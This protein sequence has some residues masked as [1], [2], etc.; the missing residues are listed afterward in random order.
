M[1]SFADKNKEKVAQR[2]PNR[3]TKKAAASVYQR[4]ESQHIRTASASANKGS[5]NV[6]LKALLEKANGSTAVQQ[7][8]SMQEQADAKGNKIAP[9]DL[10]QGK[11][12]HAVT[13]KK[14][15]PSGSSATKTALPSQLKSGVEQL[16]G[17]SMDDVQV[18]YNSDQPAQLSAHAF[19]QG[20]D[21]HIAPKQEKHLPHEAW[22]VAQ[23][24]QGRVKATTQ[25]KGKVPVNDDGSLEREADVMGAKALR[26]GTAIQ[27]TLQTK[28]ISS[29]G[30]VQKVGI[31]DKLF[32]KKKEEDASQPSVGTEAATPAT[33]APTTSEPTPEP[34]LQEKIQQ[35]RGLIEMAKH[36]QDILGNAPLWAD[37]SKKPSNT[38]ETI[39]SAGSVTGAATSAIGSAIS[40]EAVGGIVSSV[41]AEISMLFS[42]VKMANKIYAASKEKNIIAGTEAARELLSTLKSGFTFAQEV[43]KNVNAAVPTALAAA[44]PGLGIAISAANIVVNAYNGL[45]AKSAEAEMLTVSNAY[46]QDLAKLLGRPPEANKML[47]RPEKRGKLG[48]RQE[49]LRLTPDAKVVINNIKKSTDPEGEFNKRKAFYSIPPKVTFA[50]FCDAVE[51]YEL[52]SKIQEINQ[53]RKVYSGREIIK[54][55]VSIAGDI[56]AFFPADGGITAAVLKGVSGAASAAMAG[57]K[58]IQGMARDKG[59]LGADATRSSTVKH[60]EYVNHAK[61]I[62]TLLAGAGLK[63]KEDDAITSTDIAKAKSAERLLEATGAA[64]DIVY[65][66]NYKNPASLMEQVTTIVEAMKKGR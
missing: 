9:Q 60:A 34:S 40:D 53:K 21:I 43:L 46:R 23:Q 15:K 32:G 59:M 65:R 52:G 49:Y 31:F 13:Q 33:E 36:A 8:A 55:L 47:M 7:L 44:I 10:L 1:H 12:T 16:S 27:K 28:A 17:Q 18:T 26:L 5:N 54:D 38:E 3:S 30:V 62:Y 61:T 11:F 2:V 19:A 51:K 25:M 37:I 57:G 48:Q 64:P 24:K 29:Q 56:A 58:A 45:K 4:E 63:D 35:N 66:T 39:L 42:S 6:Q 41:G 50:E 22:H 20:T 14:A